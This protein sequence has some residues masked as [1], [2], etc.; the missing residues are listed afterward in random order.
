[1]WSDT[2]DLAAQRAVPLADGLRGPAIDLRLAV[3]GGELLAGVLDTLAA[4][5]SERRPPQPAG[6]TFQPWRAPEDFAL[7]GAWPAHRIFNFVRG[8]S[9][10][11]RPYR[12]VVGDRTLSVVD[13]VEWAP[14]GT[15]DQ[16]FVE[17]GWTLAVQCTPGAGV[18]VRLAR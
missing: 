17:D 10:W 12:L 6:G 7:S 3:A 13:V 16:P 5:P 1:M 9:E 2:G 4:G 18:R 11:G 14:D 15:L 8:T